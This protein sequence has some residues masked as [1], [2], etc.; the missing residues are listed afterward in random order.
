MVVLVDCE[1]DIL[2]VA[3]SHKDEVPDYL[4]QRPFPSPATGDRNALIYCVEKFWKYKLDHI[5]FWSV[6]I[7]FHVYTKAYL[8]EFSGWWPFLS[9]I[10]LRNALLAVIIYANSEFLIPE[11]AQQKKFGGYALGL[12]LCFGFYILVKN[13]HDAYLTVFTGKGQLPFWRYSFYNFSI[14]LF[15]MAFALA[16]QLSKE[17]YFQ[18]ERLRQMEVEKLNTELEFLKLQINP[19]FLFN[20]LNTIFFQIDKNNTHARDTL[21]KFADMLRFQLYE[22]NGHEMPLDKEI[23]YL[24]NY[25]DLQRLRRDDR[26]KIDFVVTGEGTSFTL[27]PL[28]LM[29]LVENAFKYIS[30]FPEGN[31][32]LA[33]HILVNP[34]ELEV[35]VKNTKDVRRPDHQPAG[36]IGLKNLRRRLELQYPGR[37]DFEINETKSEFEAV[38]K[39]K[40]QA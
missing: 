6:T 3:L 7:G 11:L 20:S 5:F 34:S 24:R 26:Y 9:E 37:H 8:V 19:H 10:I 38:L 23:A 40:S 32:K 18:R 13:T 1:N 22:C 33:I 28:L 16:L 14:S 36:G 30:N 12:L 39:L 25:V 2:K 21:T 17:W 31:N 4:D 15:Y 35:R 27:A 29:P